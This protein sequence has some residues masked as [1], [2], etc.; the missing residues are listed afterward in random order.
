LPIPSGVNPLRAPGSPVREP[1]P[2]QRGGSPRR[3][4]LSRESADPDL[5]PSP[6]L[7][8]TPLPGIRVANLSLQTAGPLR[9]QGATRSCWDPELHCLEFRAYRHQVDLKSQPF[10]SILEPKILKAR[11]K[12]KGSEGLWGG[13]GS[14]FLSTHTRKC[15]H[16]PAQPRTPH[17]AHDRTVAEVG[18]RRPRC[19]A[20]GAVELP[21]FLDGH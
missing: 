20:V 3:P 13:S 15:P 2:I 12:V 1:G 21:G 5:L 7:L 11:A 6:H 19:A 16:T 18:W 17:W 4:G 14:S 10:P 8:R 9:V